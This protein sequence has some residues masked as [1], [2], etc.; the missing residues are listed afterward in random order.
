MNPEGEPNNLGGKVFDLDARM[1]LVV[2]K[3]RPTDGKIFNLVDSKD[4][5]KVLKIGSQLDSF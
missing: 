3:T 1:P 4:T 2:K 5:T